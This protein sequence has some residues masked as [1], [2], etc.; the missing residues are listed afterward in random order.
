MTN[1]YYWP[2]SHNARKVR[3]LWRYLAVEHVTEIE[4]SMQAKEHKTSIF[5]ALNPNGQV[6]TLETPEGPVWG[7]NACLFRL[8]HG[9]TLWPESAQEQS[10]VLQWMHW[11]STDLSPLVGPIHVE[12]YFKRI[13]GLPRNETRAT[14]LIDQL[15]SKLALLNAHLAA[16]PWMVGSTISLADFALAGDFTHAENARFP[17]EDAPH[18]NTWLTSMAATTGWTDTAPPTL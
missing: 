6:P 4:L 8:A 3:A 9:S 16:R 1:L 2:M 11:Q 12:N 15:R 10:E 17:L 14:E 7:A 13:R 5:L 18:V